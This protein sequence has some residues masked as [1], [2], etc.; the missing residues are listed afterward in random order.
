MNSRK[1]FKVSRQAFVDPAIL[2]VERAQIFDKC[3]L[4]LGHSSELAKPGDFVTRQVGGPKHPV[5][6]RRQGK[7][8]GDAEH[9]SASRRAGLPREARQRQIVPVFLSRL[10]VR[11]RRY[12]AEPARGEV[13]CRGL[14]G[15][16]H[17][18]YAAG[19]AV[20][21]LSRFQF[22]LLR[23]ECREPRRLS[24][25]GQGI[26][27]CDLRPGRNRD[28]DRRRHAGILD[29]RQLEAADGKQHRRLPRADDPCDL[30]GLPEG[31][32]RRPCPGCVRGIGARSR[33]RPCRSRIQGA[34][35]PSGRAVDSV[36]GRGRQARAFAAVRR[37]GQAVRRSSAPIVS[38][39]SIATCSSS[40]ISSSTTSWR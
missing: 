25:P 8:Q 29:A 20:R 11:P 36:V 27:R 37:T 4:Y 14:Q 2:E 17:V 18:Q 7:S 39:P 15:A 5:R 21:E 34:M 30:P 22:H 32:D 19:A 24:R 3:W 31:D 38:L 16:Q 1:I 28:D 6:P 13:L 35:G 10:G 12:V 26:S 9:L 40:R 23:Q 33:Q